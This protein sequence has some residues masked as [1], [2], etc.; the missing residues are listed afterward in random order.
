M[1]KCSWCWKF[2]IACC[3]YLGVNIQLIGRPELQVGK[4]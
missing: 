4:H 3:A 2:A 1:M